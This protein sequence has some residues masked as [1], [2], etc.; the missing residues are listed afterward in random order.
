[1][2][3]AIQKEESGAWTCQATQT[4]AELQIYLYA[5]ALLFLSHISSPAHRQAEADP[6]H[7]NVCE[8]A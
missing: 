2:D 4:L 8:S 3:L 5:A 7:G 6:A 1:M